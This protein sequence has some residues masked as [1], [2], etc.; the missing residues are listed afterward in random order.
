MASARTRI[1]L[2]AATLLSGV[3]AGGAIDR[4]I[5]GGP[6]WRELGAEAWFQYSRHADLGTGLVAYPIEG[7]G[8]TLL[9]IAAVVSNYLDGNLRL[10]AALPLYGAAVFSVAGLILTAKAAPIMLGLAKAQPAAAIQNA[11]D[12][13]FLWGLYLRGAGDTLAFAALVLALTNAYRVNK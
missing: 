6:A 4:V 5:V 11:F 8:S 12:E 13:F 3:L 9:I 7:I 10:R 1:L 2:F